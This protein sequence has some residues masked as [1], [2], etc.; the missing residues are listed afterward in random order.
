[1]SRFLDVLP[2]E[3]LP[4]RE[5]KEGRQNWARLRKSFAF[6]DRGLQ[7]IEDLW[8]QR[9]HELSHQVQ[10]PRLAVDGRR[11]VPTPSFLKILSQSSELRSAAEALEDS[12]LSASCVHLR[13]WAFQLNTLPEQVLVPLWQVFMPSDIIRRK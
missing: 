5:T 1:M 12:Q 4:S 2:P 10:V 7:Q 13:K 8:A 9:C 3:M 11:A 6:V